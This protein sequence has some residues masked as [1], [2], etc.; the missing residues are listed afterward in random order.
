M[1]TLTWLVG[2]GGVDPPVDLGIC[3]SKL[4]GDVALKL[5]LEAH[6]HD[7]RERLDHRRLTVG[8]VPN[9]SDVDGRLAADDLGRQ[10]GE[11]GLVQGLEI[12][13]CGK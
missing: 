8:Y 3:V 5:V 9:R 2:L 11:L 13:Q 10:G 6:S 4:D 1:K 12:L 7:A